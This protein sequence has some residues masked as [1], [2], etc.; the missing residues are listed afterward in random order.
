MK[1]WISGLAMLVTGLISAQA[2]VIISDT[3]TGA[4]GTALAGLTTPVG[5][6]TW[7]Q[8]AGQGTFRIL[9]NSIVTQNNTESGKNPAAW[10]DYTGFTT[11]GQI[12]TM[13]LDAFV[14]DAAN[15]RIGFSA[16]SSTFSVDSSAFWVDLAADGTASFWKRSS[17]ITTQ[18]GISLD[19]KSTWNA[20]TAVELSYNHANGTVSAKAV[21]DLSGGTTNLLSA[22]ALGFTPLFNK[23]KIE[24]LDDGANT[25]TGYPAFDNLEVS[26]IPEP[27]TIG[28]LALGAVVALFARKYRR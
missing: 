19:I 5:G 17:A 23:F 21:S 18:L 14:S 7:Y 22:T 8:S 24:V 2:S 25:Q 15:M 16:L 27:A 11:A 26:V 12:T 6:S 4:D 10:V 9:G 13:K 20:V 1:K 3:F 28:M